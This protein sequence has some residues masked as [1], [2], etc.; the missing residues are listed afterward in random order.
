MKKSSKSKRCDFPSLCASIC[1]FSLAELPSLVCIE[2]WW[3]SNTPSLL[4]EASR[5]ET[6]Y[7]SPGCAGVTPQPRQWCNPSTPQ[8]WLLSQRPPGHAGSKCQGGGRI[9]ADLPGG[10]LSGPALEPVPQPSR[11]L[12]ES[13]EAGHRWCQLGAVSLQKMLQWQFLPWIKQTQ[14][15]AGDSLFLLMKQL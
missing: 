5:E 3:C 14:C 6:P 12:A 8:L 15:L 4:R 9:T 10:R 2:E 13:S 1:L 11:E 7:L